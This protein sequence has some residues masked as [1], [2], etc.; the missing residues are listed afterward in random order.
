MAEQIS[1]QQLVI[2]H[3]RIILQIGSIGAYGEVDEGYLSVLPLE[4]HFR[5]FLLP[6]DQF[7]IAPQVS[8]TCYLSDWIVEG[9]DKNAATSRVVEATESLRHVAGLNGVEIKTGRRGAFYSD[10]YVDPN[11]AWYGRDMEDISVAV[12]SVIHSLPYYQ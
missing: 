6:T 10:T 12:H 2:P 11:T 8:T 9:P 1:N 5:G 4:A 7:A 3:H